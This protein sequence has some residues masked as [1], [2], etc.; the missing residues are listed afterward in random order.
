[1]PSQ[2]C[3]IQHCLSYRC[4]YT[5]IPSQYVTQNRILVN[6][7]LPAESNGRMHECLC[8]SMI[9]CTKYMATRI[10]AMI[11]ILLDRLMLVF[12][13]LCMQRRRM[14]AHT[15]TNFRQ[16]SSSRCVSPEGYCRME[17]LKPAGMY[18]VS[19]QENIWTG[20]IVRPC[21]ECEHASQSHGINISPIRRFLDPAPCPCQGT[22]RLAAT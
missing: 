14:F 11:G 5:A 20:Q 12:L 17:C 10:D 7:H 15:Q 13:Y 22:G 16:I 3:T 1:M 18:V 2:S 8:A 6:L 21:A 19:V 9:C 4:S